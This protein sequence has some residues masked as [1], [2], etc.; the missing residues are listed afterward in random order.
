MGLRTQ[1]EGTCARIVTAIALMVEA[2]SLGI[3]ELAP[4]VAVIA[5]RRRLA[6]VQGGR[7]RAVVRLE[8]KVIVLIVCGELLQPVRQSAAIENVAS[9]VGRLPKSVDGHE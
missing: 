7:P 3:I 1:I 5:R 4:C 9:A 8:E 2:V 6:A